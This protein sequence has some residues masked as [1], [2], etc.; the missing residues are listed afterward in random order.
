MISPL[1]ASKRYY[2]SQS[3]AEIPQN[4][5]SVTQTI[6]EDGIMVSKTYFVRLEDANHCYTVRAIYVVLTH[7]IAMKNNF[8]I[9]DFLNDSS[10]NF[11]LNQLDASILGLQYGTVSY[12]ANPSDN[13]PIT[14]FN[15]IGSATIYVKVTVNQCSETY[16]INLKLVPTPI[17]APSI[18]NALYNICDINND[19]VE[20]YNL[21]QH[22]PQIYS[23]TDPVTFSY[24][25]S[26]NDAS[27]TFSGLISDP[28]NFLAAPNTTVYAKIQFNTGGCFSVSKINI[29]MTFL[30]TIVL[31]AATLK[32][33]DK[34]FNFNEKFD[35]KDA[36]PQLFLQT[37]N[38]ISLAD[39]TITYYENEEDA[40]AGL[41]TTQISNIQHPLE[42]LKTVYARFQSNQ[43]QCYSVKP[44]LLKTYFPPKAITYT[45]TDIFDHN[46]DGKPEVNS[47]NYTGFM[48]GVPDPEN[49]FSFYLSQTDI[50]NNKPIPNPANFEATPF[51][52]KIWVKVENLPGRSD[53]DK[54]NLQMGTNV[55][56]IK[57]GPFHI[58]DICDTGKYGKE[59]I[60]LKQ[61]EPE[62]FAGG[63]FEYYKTIEDL[64]SGQNKIQNADSF[65]YE[66]NVQGNR[67]FVKINAAGYC[68]NKAEIIIQLK[69]TP[70]FSI[71]DHYFCKKTGSV[72][73]QPDFS[74]LNI[75][76][77]EWKD[78]SGQ[79]V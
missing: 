28:A 66:A 76:T 49:S 57:S 74:G 31:H 5:I 24:Y 11:I 51:P 54:I 47:M 17:V 50:Q 12:L 21:T 41:A 20:P 58:N 30:P 32:K 59:N 33:C 8:D 26:Y 64:H 35:L 22:E 42:S 44:I 43:L 78:P 46:L 77:F 61:F 67:I 25:R 29:Q 72:D 34:D 79:I 48:I 73:I 71:A 18:N 36:T 60:N 69:V 2:K 40:N 62:M 23:G 4:E 45:I 56:L 37:E 7:P 68:P 38:S 70:I 55:P 53:F 9:C 63:N 39:I 52:A 75:K 16:P 3:D 27:Q 10:G 15:L 1:T 14:N 6:T 13:S 19:A 65:P